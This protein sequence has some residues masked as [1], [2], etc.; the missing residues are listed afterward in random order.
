M[1]PLLSFLLSLLITGAGSAGELTVARGDSVFAVVTHKAG[2]FSG[3]AHD[4]LVAAGD[5]AARLEASA[6]A[7]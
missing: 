5:Y 1:R 7:S 3:R 2:L 4:P 6:G